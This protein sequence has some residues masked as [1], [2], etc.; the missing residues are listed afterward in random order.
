[1]GRSGKQLDRTFGKV[2]NQIDVLIELKCFL[3]ET[4]RLFVLHALIMIALIMIK[5][6]PDLLP[7]YKRLCIEFPANSLIA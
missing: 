2:S 4:C 1:M 6:L 5:V 7:P 3:S